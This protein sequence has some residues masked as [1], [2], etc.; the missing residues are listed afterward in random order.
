MRI[1]LESYKSLIKSSHLNWIIKD[2]AYIGRLKKYF[3]HIV[4]V[5]ERRVASLFFLW[6]T[7]YAVILIKMLSKILINR[8]QSGA[9]RSDK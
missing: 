4:D 1:I 2:A 9:R 7:P 6:K 3:H 8:V 5:I